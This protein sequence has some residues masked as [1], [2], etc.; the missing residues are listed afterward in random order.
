MGLQSALGYEFRRPNFFQR[1]NQRLA[2]ST[3]GARV[4]ARITQPLDGLVD[5]LTKGRT[6]ASQVL[7]GLPVV[8]VTTTGRKSGQPRTAPLIALPI[9]GELALVGSNFGGASTPAWVYNLEADPSATV[10][11]EGSEV[12]ATA[13]PATD[14]EYE[15]IFADSAQY[16]AGYQKYRGRVT[17]RDIRVFVLT[18]A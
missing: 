8:N 15:R 3:V 4:F 7:A 13:R 17:G 6:S 9:D 11:F 2:S 18:E 16:Y 5:R 10:G 12:E 14:E 1:A